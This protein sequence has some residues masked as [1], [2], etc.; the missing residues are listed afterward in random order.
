MLDSPHEA[1]VYQGAAAG[2]ETGIPA[3]VK[4]LRSP[5]IPVAVTERL[6]IFGEARL[7]MQHRAAC[8]FSL[9]GTCPN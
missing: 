2:G 6:L 1:V 7:E 5:L 3:F 4:R 9:P 8:R